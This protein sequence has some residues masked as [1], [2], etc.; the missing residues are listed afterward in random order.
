[1]HRVQ[2]GSPGDMGPVPASGASVA[3]FAGIGGRAQPRDRGRAPL[4][5]APGQCGAGAGSLPVA[6]GGD[7][8]G[9]DA[10]GGPDHRGRGGAGRPRPARPLPCPVA[11]AADSSPA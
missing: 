6:G 4:R 3:R 2:A 11:A 10:G 1:M 8:G 7:A 9:G 5:S